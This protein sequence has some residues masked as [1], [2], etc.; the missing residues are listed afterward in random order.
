MAAA[1]TDLNIAERASPSAMVHERVCAGTANYFKGAMIAIDYAVA[2]APFIRATAGDLNAR[3]VG[4]C[5]ET[6]SLAA[7]NSSS[8]TLKAKSGIFRYA[9]VTVGTADVGKPCYVI[10]DQTV[11]CDAGGTVNAIAGRVYEVEGSGAFVWV[12]F[13]P[14][15]VNLGATAGA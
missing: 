4:R 6:K 1:T 14:F 10:D 13:D 12:K 2:G 5:E 7:I 11:T 15:T 9:G 8:I 3:V